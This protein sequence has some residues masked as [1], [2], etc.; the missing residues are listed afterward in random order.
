[1]KFT[2]KSVTLVAALLMATTG[3]ITTLSSN[4]T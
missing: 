1:M 4:S 2:S 3:A